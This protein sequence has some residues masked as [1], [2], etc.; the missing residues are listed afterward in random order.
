MIVLS[1]VGCLIACLTSFRG[2]THLMLPSVLETMVEQGNYF[3]YPL[4]PK[5]S[6][7][8][9]LHSFRVH[10]EVRSGRAQCPFLTRL[11]EDASNAGV[12]DM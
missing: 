4:N 1:A 9:I 10:V 2:T 11:W 12:E 8:Q 3:T 5:L 7:A 6:K